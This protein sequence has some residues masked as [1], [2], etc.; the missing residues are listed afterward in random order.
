MSGALLPFAVAAT[1]GVLAALLLIRASPPLAW[2]SLATLALLALAVLSRAQSP[3][4]PL[5]ASTQAYIYLAAPP[6]AAALAAYG[7]FRIDYK[8]AAEWLG[9]ALLILA[10]LAYGYIAV[11]VLLVTA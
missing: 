7:W 5:A 8:L 6:V 3:D 2:A 11:L 4:W 10:A 1:C 9:V